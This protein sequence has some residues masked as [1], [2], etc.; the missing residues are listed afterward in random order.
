MY[1]NW[2]MCFFQNT[3]I[4]GGDTIV[5]P[6][7]FGFNNLVSQ[8]GWTSEMGKMFYEHI[9]GRRVRSWPDLS[10][11]LVKPDSECVYYSSSTQTGT[12]QM[13]VTGGQ[14][15]NY[16]YK[17]TNWVGVVTQHCSHAW[18]E[19]TTQFTVDFGSVHYND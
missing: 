14:G 15:M 11:Q 3:Y 8:S 2:G 1:G 10:R 18:L 19:R 4:V 7:Y 17:K 16:F 12:G 13:I 9:S 5:D 6:R